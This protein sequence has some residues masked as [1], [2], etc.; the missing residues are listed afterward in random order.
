MFVFSSQVICG[1]RKVF[2]AACSGTVR[3]TKEIFIPKEDQPLAK[4]VATFP[5]GAL[6][7]KTFI[8]V[9]P[10]RDVGRFRLVET[11]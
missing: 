2:N 8:N 6:L 3:F 1:R 9:V 4:T 7:Y 5:R 10:P 11:I